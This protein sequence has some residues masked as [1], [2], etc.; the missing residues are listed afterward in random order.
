MTH[1][2]S[3]EPYLRDISAER[4]API[5][6]RAVETRE[7]L[8]T[9]M[10]GYTGVL[11][12]RASGTA[13]SFAMTAP[14]RSAHELALAGR[15]AMWIFA[16]DDVL[17]A[18]DA[19]AVTTTGLLAPILA[20]LASGGEQRPVGDAPLVRALGDLWERLAQRPLY[21]FFRGPLV[22]SLQAMFAAME[23]ENAWR[24]QY[25]GP[26]RR[27]PSY[28]DYLE[29]GISS[30]AMPCLYRALALALG[31]PATP[32]CWPRLRSIERDA[33]M[34]VRLANDLR[35]CTRELDEQAVNAVVILGESATVAQARGEVEADMKRALDRCARSCEWGAPEPAG[36]DRLFCDY[37]VHT[38]RLYAHG[39][40]NDGRLAAAV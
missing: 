11:D 30:I 17:D 31:G 29:N 22:E 13:L 25:R 28:P 32:S 15:L 33:A 10:A 39:D 1:V 2:C 21:P 27:L 12:P 3:I 7:L 8:A 36:L 9:W 24:E 6:A 16:V 34:A 14:T 19:T 37:A 35:T 4:R 5:L 18:R 40:F 38:C 23:L 26:G 20:F